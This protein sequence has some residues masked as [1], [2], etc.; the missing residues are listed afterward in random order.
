MPETSKP[1]SR[2][3]V[4]VKPGVSRRHVLLGAGAAAGTLLLADC[5]GGNKGGSG[6]NSGGGTAAGGKGSSKQ[7]VA[8]PAKFSEAPMLADMVKSG[9]LPKLEER[10]PANPYVAPHNWP[11]KGKYGGVINMTMASTD[12]SVPY[13]YCYGH[14]ILRLLN[15]GLDVGPGL[16]EKWEASADLKTFT[17]HFRDGLKWSD[18]QP[19]STDDIMYWWDDMVLN[20]Q[21]SDTP[22]DDT[23]D[24]KDQIAKVTAPDKLTLKLEFQN[25][26]PA[27]VERIAAWVNGID[28]GPRWMVPKHYMKQFHPKYNKS[29]NGKSGDWVTKHDQKLR[30]A[31]N[32]DY[33]TM[34]GWHVKSVKDGQTTLWERNPYYYVVSKD[35]DQLPYLDHIQWLV[36][37]DP[38]VQKVQ[39]TTGKFDYVHGPHSSL[40]LADFQQ[41]K[42]AE[43]GGKIQ[44]F[45]WDSGS[46]TGSITFFNHEHPD[47]KLR[48]LIGKRDFRVALSHAFNRPEAKKTIYFEQGELTSGTLSPKGS[49]FQVNDQA[50]QIYAQWRDAWLQYD[51]AKAKSMLDALGLKAGGDGFRQY[52]DGGQIQISLDYP[53]NTTK[54]HINKC[55]QLARD[56]NAVGIK[57]RLNPTAPTTFGER[58]GVGQLTTTTAWEVGDCSPFIYAGWVVPV[59]SAHWAPLSGQAY[60]MKL[61]APKTLTDKAQLDREPWK[62]TPPFA[63][64]SDHLPISATVAKLQNTY[65]KARVETDSTKQL[66]LTWDIYKIHINE[67]PFFYGIVANYPQAIVQHPDM[68][69]IPRRENLALGGWT[70]P[71]ILPSP[72][73]YDPE[74]YYWDNPDQHS[75]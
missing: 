53:S 16:A 44:V 26:A 62:R 60:T 1:E 32:P 72:A 63:V 25:P 68:R 2:N 23:R 42:A 71:W 21:Q 31:K 54:E 55:T 75:A 58:W 66:S 15:D 70:N 46:G 36:S 35:G 43:S 12:D 11:A 10:I 51:Q 61:S 28:I 34:T 52:P 8:K 5:G 3:P 14:S 47:K 59:Q 29:I 20:E 24:G 50:K 40:T 13:E 22:P 67:G 30:W 4:P 69:N 57:T 56:W 33:P 17:F 65:D 48:D 38:Q 19:W 73:V 27:T 9:K 6:D 45:T 41:L 7:V 37:S 49:S 18:G 74:L 64:E 39:I